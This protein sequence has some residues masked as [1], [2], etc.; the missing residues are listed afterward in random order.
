MPELAR[1]SVGLRIFG[2]ALDPD[3]ITRLLG[4]EPTGCARRGDT[5]RTASGRE[6]VARSGSWRLDAGL[7]GDLNTQISALLTKL[8]SDP[9]IWRKLSEHYECDVFCGLFM[10]EGNEGTELSPL[11]M[12]MLA[13]RGLR[14]GLDIYGGSD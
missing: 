12:S 14:L 7:P 4:V 8:P 6:V 2:E 13:I 3:E 10:R 11:V 9:I 1:I 5:H